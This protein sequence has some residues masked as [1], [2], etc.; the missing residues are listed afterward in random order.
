M[1]DKI[2]QVMLMGGRLVFLC[3]T[4]AERGNFNRID[5]TE[6]VDSKLAAQAKALER[7]RMAIEDC[8][9]WPGAIGQ[10]QRLEKALQDIEE[11]LK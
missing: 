6:I 11:A 10:N 3:K 9:S 1:E 7:A 5:I 4:C 8:L 2:S